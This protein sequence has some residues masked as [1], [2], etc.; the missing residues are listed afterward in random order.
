MSLKIKSC[1]ILLIITVLICAGIIF[2]RF[3]DF[4]VSKDVPKEE[5]HTNQRIDIA[6]LIGRWQRPDGGYVIAILKSHADGKL[7]AAYYNPSPINIARAEFLQKENKVSIFIELRDDGYPGSTYNLDYDPKH[8]ILIGTY[9]H[10]TLK[11]NFKI[12]FRRVKKD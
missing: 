4:E 3:S 1:I 8:D 11:R 9:F 6:A 5:E 7:D 12:I 2:N 10:A